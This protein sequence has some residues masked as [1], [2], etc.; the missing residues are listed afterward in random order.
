[1]ILIPPS[2]C[3]NNYD[4]PFSAQRS[5]QTVATAERSAVATVS[6]L[7]FYY[8][9]YFILLQQACP[10]VASA[11]YIH[12][13]LLQQ[14][15][16][17]FPLQPSHGHEARRFSASALLSTGAMSCCN[18]VLPY[19]V[20]VYIYFLYYFCCNSEI[21]FTFFFGSRPLQ[22]SRGHKLDS[23]LSVATV[24]LQLAVRPLCILYHFCCN[25]KCLPRQACCNSH[26]IIIYTFFFGSCLPL[27]VA[28]V[29]R[30]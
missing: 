15:P 26:I 9:L 18:S 2:L 17:A 16:S 25:N 8:I 1:M 11:I 22:P 6:I 20:Y 4:T 21:V 24:L 12:L 10:G 3:C 30:S 13:F 14:L 27:P 23:A 28:T 19:V 7:I 5:A 29:T